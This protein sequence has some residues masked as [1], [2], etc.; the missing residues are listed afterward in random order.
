MRFDLGG[1]SVEAEMGIAAMMIYEQEFGR[2]IIQDLFGVIN[3]ST[4]SKPAIQDVEDTDEVLN[5]AARIIEDD[6]VL[7]DFTTTN[8]TAVV[9]ALWA[10][11]KAVDNSIPPFKIW[12]LSVGDIDLFIISREI[13]DAA[14]GAFF[15]PAASEI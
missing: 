12:S 3:I 8:W 10:S 15:R 6:T 4:K 2:D 5:T 1:R 13:I 7:Y 11:I 9:R 14:S